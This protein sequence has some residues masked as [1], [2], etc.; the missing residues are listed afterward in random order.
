MKSMVV[1]RTVLDLVQRQAEEL[2]RLRKNIGNYHL[3]EFEMHKE[4]AATLQRAMDVGM[5]KLDIK[6]YILKIMG[7]NPKDHSVAEQVNTT[8]EALKKNLKE[9][10]DLHL[11]TCQEIAL[12]SLLVDDE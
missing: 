7:P 1:P 3:A 12:G 5:E 10:E 8:F 9:V 4:Y 11:L 6:P 2:D